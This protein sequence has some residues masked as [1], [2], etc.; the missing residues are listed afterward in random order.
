MARL[1]S[2]SLKTKGKMRKWIFVVFA[3][4]WI[5][6]HAQEQEAKRV[7]DALKAGNSAEIGA[8]L[9]NQVDL[10]LLK[11]EDVFPKDQVVRK[12]NTFFG[13]NKPSAYSNRHQGTSKLNDHYY[14]GELVTDKGKFRVTYFIKR[15]GGGFKVSQLR[16]ESSD[17]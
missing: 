7:A 4:G 16:I 17:E 11:E 5:A 12:L 10:T 2:N 9:G 6:T 15:D 13:A 8:L 3:F 14:I 1:L